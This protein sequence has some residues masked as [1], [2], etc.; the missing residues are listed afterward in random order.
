MTIVVSVS[1][2]F[3]VCF[4][5]KNIVEIPHIEVAGVELVA[6]RA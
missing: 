3:C 4:L 1:E 5:H 6:Q 2:P